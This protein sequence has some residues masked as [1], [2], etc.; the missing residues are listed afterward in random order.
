[1][2]FSAGTG[3]FRDFRADVVVT[4]DPKDPAVWHWD[5]RYR[6]GRSDEDD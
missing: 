4:Q 6:I 1:M 5:G 2:T 3:R